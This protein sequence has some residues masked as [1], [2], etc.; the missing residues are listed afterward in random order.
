V[1][2]HRVT[3][4]ATLLSCPA[5]LTAWAQGC[6]GTGNQPLPTVVS[7]AVTRAN[8]PANERQ[9]ESHEVSVIGGHATD[10]DVRIDI[11]LSFDVSSECG[12]PID[13]FDPA[14]SV[15]QRL[16]QS[17][18]GSAGRVFQPA[19]LDR[20]HEH[21][22]DGSN[23]LAI[24]LRTLARFGDG[25]ETV[26]FTIGNSLSRVAT[27][28][29]PFTVTRSPIDDFAVT[30]STTSAAIGTEVVVTAMMP[31]ALQLNGMS[32]PVQF[33]VEPASAGRFIVNGGSS[34]IN[35]TLLPPRA[36]TRFEPAEVQSPVNATIR[37]SLPIGSRTATFLVLASAGVCRPIGAY[38]VTPNGIVL[39]VT[40]VGDRT[41]PTY[42][43]E[44]LSL[45]GLPFDS[46]RLP[47]LTPAP[48]TSTKATEPI[49]PTSKAYRPKSTAASPPSSSS[50]WTRR[51]RSAAGTPQVGTTVVFRLTP[52][53]LGGSPVVLDTFTVTNL[54]GTVPIRDQPSPRP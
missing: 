53:S 44:M 38:A 9:K 36:E 18:S 7:Y 3:A 23:N 15:E 45:N 1:S 20:R 10:G 34:R 14:L 12:L 37:A 19:S 27:P 42:I 41:C 32:G 16:R 31:A 26:A 52:T 8:G 4:L 51:F 50:S 28:A 39:T 33:T 11:R 46:G 29:Y 5:P 49:K 13:V 2:I 30:L 25:I 17:G 21:F 35:Y 24:V 43:A 6:P 54:R 22:T 47:A 40:N 48:R